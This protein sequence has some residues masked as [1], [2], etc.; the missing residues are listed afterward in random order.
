MLRLKNLHQNPS[1]ASTLPTDE[2]LTVKAYTVNDIWN[3][4]CESP[5]I[6]CTSRG[7]LKLIGATY[8]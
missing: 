2:G 8:N 4:I 1:K 6:T 7:T 3:W 5:P